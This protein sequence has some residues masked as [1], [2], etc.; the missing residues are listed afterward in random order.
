[1]PGYFTNGIDRPTGPMYFL[2]EAQADYKQIAGALFLHDIVIAAK[3]GANVSAA[4]VL[5]AMASVD[6]NLPVISIRTLREQ[7]ASQFTQPRLIA[8]LTSFFG[9]LSVLSGFYR[10]LWRDGIQCRMPHCRNRREDGTGG[11]S[12][13]HCPAGPQRS[14]HSDSLGIVDRAALDAC[15]GAISGQSALW[16][17]SA[18]TQ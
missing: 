15:G 11:K 14:R 18:T 2:P 5:R 17:E 3:P 8:R 9:V 1:M 7:V 16:H 10:A 12:R 13:Q 6:S 4:S